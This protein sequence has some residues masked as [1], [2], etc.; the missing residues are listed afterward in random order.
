MTRIPNDAGKNTFTNSAA[1]EASIGFN[2]AADGHNAPL[3]PPQDSNPHPV[4][5]PE[6]DAPAVSGYI[7]STSCGYDHL[8][9]HGRL[10]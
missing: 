3:F 5:P 7:R 4:S 1:I 8:A 9:R 6:R 2:S 10:K